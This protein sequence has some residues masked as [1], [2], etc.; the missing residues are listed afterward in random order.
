MIAS[1]ELLGALVGL[2]V[3]GP[4][5]RGCGSLVGTTTFTCG[6]DDRSNTYLL[7]RMLTTLYPLGLV[8]MELAAQT[9]LRSVIIRGRWPP[10]LHNDA[11]DALSNFEF[12]SFDEKLG[13]E[14]EEDDMGRL[15]LP[16][17]LLNDLFDAG[18]AY[19]SE[20]VNV[21]E[22]ERAVAKASGGAPP[23][24]KKKLKGEGL[25]DKDPW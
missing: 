18:D 8:L 5:P 25:K 6:T 1:F 9:H 15:K 17:L 23:R 24:R 11:T 20:L 22:K 21:K 10:R 7:H 2:M 13:I 12:D 16:L 19:I 4:V 3:L 14:F